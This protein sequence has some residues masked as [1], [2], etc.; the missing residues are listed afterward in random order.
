MC[1]FLSRLLLIVAF[2]AVAACST[3]IRP[4]LARLYKVGTGPADTTPV[5][6]IPGLF[7]ISLGPHRAKLLG[8]AAREGAIPSGGRA[9]VDPLQSAACASCALPRSGL[10]R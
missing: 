8:E 10:S 1:A 3:P 7:V 2:L 6:V 4:D 9:K 5:I